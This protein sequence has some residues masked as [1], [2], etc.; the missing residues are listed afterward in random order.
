MQDNSGISPSVLLLSLATSWMALQLPTDMWSRSP[1]GRANSLALSSASSTPS[2][3]RAGMSPAYTWG[4]CR[5]APAPT[6]Q[7]LQMEYW[8]D[9]IVT[10]VSAVLSLK[11]DTFLDFLIKESVKL[12][13]IIIQSSKCSFATVITGACCFSFLWFNFSVFFKMHDYSHLNCC[14]YHDAITSN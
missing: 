11:R 4:A 2:A 10:I 5:E 14:S 3:G 13:N 8:R 6:L 1:R 12:F 9:H 7:A